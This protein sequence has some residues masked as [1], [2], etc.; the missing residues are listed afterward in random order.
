MIHMPRRSVTRFFIPLIDVL[1][2]LFCIFLLMEFNNESKFVEQSVDVELQSATM[3]GVEDELT[4]RTKE[5]EKFEKLQPELA[6]VE[7]LLK[8]IADL[9]ENNLRDVQ[10]RMFFR[11]INIDRK[12][13]HISFYDAA[14]DDPITPIKSRQDAQG[15][16]QR[17]TKEAKGR[18]VYYYFLMPVPR[19]GFPT[20]P[21]LREYAGWFDAKGVATNLPK[22]KKQ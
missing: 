19:G 2:L 1:I 15:L 8:R 17:H 13:G 14:A 22:G 20:G 16:I 18:T 21:Q 7:E 5:L 10:E 4:R 11:E 6:R 3:Q 12:D 9:E